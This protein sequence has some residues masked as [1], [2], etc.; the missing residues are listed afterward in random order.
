MNDTLVASSLRLFNCVPAASFDENAAEIKILTKLGIVVAPSAMPLYSEICSFYEK[1][2][3][4][5]DKINKTFFEDFE[6]TRETPL[7]ERLMHQLWH[8]FTTYGLMSMGID[9][10]DFIYIPSRVTEA[11]DLSSPPIVVIRGVELG[12]LID[13]GLSMICSG[14]ALAEQ[15]I[16]DIL[17]VLDFCNYKFSGAE[18]IRNREVANYVYQKLGILPNTNTDALFRYLVFL[19]TG[20]TLVINNAAFLDKVQSSSFDLSSVPGLTNTHLKTLSIEFNRRKPF[21]MAFKRAHP[22][23]RRIVNRISKFSK[24][25]HLPLPKNVLGS[26]THEHFPEAVIVG[27][28]RSATPFGVA[29]A[30]N[31]VNYYLGSE[32]NYR[33]YRI[34]N[35]KGFLKCDDAKYH[36]DADYLSTARNLLMDSL[37]E[38]LSS[39]KVF[40]PGGVEYALPTSEKMFS[41][42]V[43]TNTTIVLP[44]DTEKKILVGVY[45][46]N[47]A[48][49]SHYD[50]DLSSLLLSGQKI[51]WN[52]SWNYEGLTYTGDITNAPRGAAEWF[53]VGNLEESALVTANLYSRHDR[54]DPENKNAKFTIMVGITENSSGRL[55][56]ILK[57][58][59]ILL[60]AESS[61]CSKQ[62]IVGHLS[63]GEDGQ[64]RFTLVDQGFQN[65]HIAVPGHGTQSLLPVLCEQ[66]ELSQPL[67]PLLNVVPSVEEADIDLSPSALSK[68][69]ILSLFS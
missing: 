33:Y 43:P 4:T 30:L 64:R 52:A 6:R 38:R 1:N 53:E 58:E 20:E 51:G 23:N 68:D 22:S 11:P 29:R 13:R 26:L 16:Q 18:E 21:W 65:R 62:M 48:T 9:S 28:A 63:K 5:A 27:A 19:A 42:N 49:C 60:S 57:P 47:G 66:I 50:I 8:Y 25:L 54:E 3:L 7:A 44:N 67:R 32:K 40:I 36:R 55:G 69:S 61:F 39:K 17:N 59:E 34:R 12:E 41:G 45:W 37:K 10:P 2:A 24:V 35:G 14:V 15:T 46:E 56:Y 31:A